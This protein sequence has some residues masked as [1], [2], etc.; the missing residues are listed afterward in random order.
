MYEPRNLNG[1]VF[2]FSGNAFAP[3]SLSKFITLAIGRLDRDLSPIKFIV[4]GYVE[5]SP[6]INL[7]VVP[8]F[9]Q[10]MVPLYSLSPPTTK[11]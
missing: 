9:P 5:S 11:P 3:N 4:I 10:L 8:L 1:I 7:A 2:L 6:I